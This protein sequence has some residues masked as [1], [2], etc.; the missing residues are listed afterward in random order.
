MNNNGIDGYYKKFNCKKNVICSG[1]DASGM[2][3]TYQKENCWVLDSSRIL[4]P[5]FENFNKYIAFFFITLFNKNMIKFSYGQK[6]NPKKIEN[7]IIKLPV[8][9]KGNP[10][11]EYMENYIKSLPYSKYL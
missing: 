7:I 1:G 11:W 10:D 2:Y 9:N 6:A 4:E 5:K 8:D 3:S